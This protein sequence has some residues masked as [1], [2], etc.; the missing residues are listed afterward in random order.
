MMNRQRIAL[1]ADWKTSARFTICLVALLFLVTAC[2]TTSEPTRPVPEQATEEAQQVEESE[3]VLQVGIGA[4]PRNMDLL[5]A[6]DGQRDLFQFSVYESLTFRSS[7]DLKIE[8]LLAESWEADGTTWTFHLREGV[9]FHN[10]DTLTSA[11][12]VASIQRMLN[13]D[14]ELAGSRAAGIIEVN[15]IDDTTVEIVTETPDPT[16][17][18]KVALIGIAPAEL[19][20]LSSDRLSSEMVGTG[21]YQFVTWNRGEEIILEA[22]ADYLGDQ[23]EIDRVVLKF[24]PEASTRLAAIRAG[25]ID[26]ALNMPTE[27]EAQAPQVITAPSP[28]VY[29]LFMNT[30]S[31]PLAEDVRLREAINYAIDRQAIIDQLLGGHGETVKGQYVGQYVFGTTPVLDEFPFEP[32]QARQLLEDA[33]A[34]GTKITLSATTG[35]WPKDRE[36]AEAVAAMLDDV[37]FDVNLHLPVFSEWLDGLFAEN[38]EIDL[39][40]AGHGNELFDM[41]RSVIWVTCGGALSHYCNE[42]VD[43]LIEQARQELDQDRRT[44]LYEQMWQAVREDAPYA[45]LTTI[46]QV[47]FAS[48][49]LDWSPRPDNFILFD[50]VS[51]K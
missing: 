39:W 4:E 50:E 25:E 11:D 31:G 32:D 20:D 51:M 37:G 15:K 3:E 24:L 5:T 12:V 18:A 42:D 43:L 17:P 40:L 44:E 7:D 1:T 49:D 27:F 47:H 28:D 14:S 48:E 35:R 41:E 16:V 22:F 36:I 10:G 34:V 30:L 21:P 19:A 38:P 26:L 8:P 6:E 46:E 29:T 33:G 2:S 45:S 23:P 13:P 9:K